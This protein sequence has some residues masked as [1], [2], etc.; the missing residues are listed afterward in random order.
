MVSF[1]WMI[2]YFGMK[3]VGR[4]LITSLSWFLVNWVILPSD[5]M[6]KLSHHKFLMAYVLVLAQLA[7]RRFRI[8]LW[9]DFQPFLQIICNSQ[10]IIEMVRLIKVVRSNMIFTLSWQDLNIVKDVHFVCGVDDIRPMV[11]MIKENY[12]NDYYWVWQ[13]G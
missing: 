13:A 6:K 11:C 3:G 9:R 1:G 2:V 8:L 5:M 7:A 4:E 10:F 12:W